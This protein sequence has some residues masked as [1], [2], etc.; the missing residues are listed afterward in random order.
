[1]LLMQKSL[2]EGPKDDQFFMGYGTFIYASMASA[3]VIETERWDAVQ[4]LFEPLQNNPALSSL[5]G[6]PGPYQSLAQYI[7]ALGIFTRG[8]AAAQQ[9]SPDAQKSIKELQALAQQAG[10]APLPGI[11]VPLS[12]VLEMQRLEIVARSNAA[13]GNMDEAIKNMEKATALEGSVPPPPGPPPLI[14]PSHEFA[15]EILLEAKRPREAAE[16][17]V[18][19]NYR[20]TPQHLVFY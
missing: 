7:Q 2:A 5:A 4:K 20:G 8:L 19:G 10:K 14:K 15:G 3:F 9:S 1:L 16:Q 17:W 12:R 13:K 11:G 18:F 6:K